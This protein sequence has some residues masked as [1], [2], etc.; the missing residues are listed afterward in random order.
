MTKKNYIAIANIIKN[1]KISATTHVNKIIGEA[2][3]TTADY[4]ARELAVIMQEDNDQ[5]NR[6]KFLTA[7]GVKLRS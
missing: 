1:A 4:I 2:E 3:N 7:C 5:F 6:D